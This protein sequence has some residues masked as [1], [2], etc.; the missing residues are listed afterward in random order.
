[1]AL[2]LS[3][4]LIGVNSSEYLHR[5]EL[6]Q[7]MPS[8]SG[9]QRGLGHPPNEAR[10]RALRLTVKTMPHKFRAIK[11]ER[12]VWQGSSTILLPAD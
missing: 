11:Q 8:P 2:L 1:M 10:T 7:L 4:L 6:F 9:H 3:E 5:H 12:V